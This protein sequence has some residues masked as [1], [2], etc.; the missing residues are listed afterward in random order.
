MKYFIAL[1][2]RITG[3]K[4]KDPEI[5]LLFLISFYIYNYDYK[6]TTTQYRKFDYK[7]QIIMV[8]DI[9]FIRHRQIIDL[10]CLQIY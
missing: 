2:T 1:K 6:F 5:P 8:I 10:N 3:I 7:I 4:V 9:T